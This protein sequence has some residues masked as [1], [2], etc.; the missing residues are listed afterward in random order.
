MRGQVAFEYMVIVILVLLFLVPVWIYITNMQNETNTEFILS[1]SKLATKEL[2]SSADLL[3][4]QGP[5]AKISADIYIPSNVQEIIIQNN[6][7]IFKVYFKN[8]ITDVFSTSDSQL[9]GS[10][11]S[12]EGNYRVTM[13]AMD[14]FV[15]IGI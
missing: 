11:P 6:S 4:S 8:T 12:N 7:V 1:Y 5:P 13:E 9:N 10:L 15:Q 2:T 3:Y 14:G